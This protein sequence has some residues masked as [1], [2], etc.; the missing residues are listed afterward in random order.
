MK[1]TDISRIRRLLTKPVKTKE[2]LYYMYSV[3]SKTGLSE[4]FFKL[5]NEKNRTPEKMQEICKDFKYQF[6]AK[7]DVVFKEGDSETDSLYFILT[8]KV[9]AFIKSAVR[10]R[11]TEIKDKPLDVP[12]NRKRSKLFTPQDKE[13]M[14]ALLNK[15]STE[16][17]TL[18]SLYKLQRKNT[19][20]KNE[21]EPIFKT[22]PPEDNNPLPIIKLHTASRNISNKSETEQKS[23]KKISRSKITINFFKKMKN[24]QFLSANDEQSSKLLRL[25]EKFLNN[26]KKEIPEDTMRALEK[27]YGPMVNDV[28][29]GS[30]F[31]EKAVENLRPRSATVI[32]LA[33]TELIVISQSNFRI[34][35]RES[36][37]IKKQ[38]MINFLI[39]SFRCEL[40]PHDHRL[41][42]NSLTFI[43][44]N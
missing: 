16:E 3:L 40:K 42:Y 22:C 35:I 17:K 36:L 39:E 29:E 12:V 23:P 37:K 5:I 1:D 6:C 14:R 21:K 18:N 43:K 26:D 19:V 31:G 8:G 4:N 44:V 27:I 20:E 2:D 38:K 13:N 34:F 15:G 33:N 28:A 24:F 7:G 32:A 25:F 9:G 10:A 41:L 30:T 11:Q